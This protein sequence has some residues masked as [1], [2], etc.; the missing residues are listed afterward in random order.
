MLGLGS[1]GR[2]YSFFL[3]IAEFIPHKNRSLFVNCTCFEGIEL[4]YYD[5]EKNYFK[6]IFVLFQYLIHFK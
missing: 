5:E 2:G 6:E 1:K 4:C 3:I